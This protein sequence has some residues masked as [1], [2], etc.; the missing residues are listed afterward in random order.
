MTTKSSVFGERNFLFY[1][2]GAGFSLHGTWIQRFAQGWFAWELTS[3]EAWVGVIAFLDFFPVAMLAPAFGVV[4]DRVDRAKMMAWANGLMMLNIAILTIFTLLESVDIIVL[5]I[6]VLIQGILNAMNTPAR[7]SL[8]PNLVSKSKIGSALAS[9]ALLFN[10]SRFIGPAIGGVII[11]VWGVAAAFAINTVTFLIFAI[12]LKQIKL[13]AAHGSGKRHPFRE[14]T[15]G[16]FY[17]LQRPS[18]IWSLIMII[19]VG[20]CVRGAMELMPAFSDVFFGLGSNGQAALT[21]AAGAGAIIG[22]LALASPKSSNTLF[23]WVVGSAG[24]AGISLIVFAI[25]SHFW[26]ALLLMACMGMTVTI[27]GVGVQIIIQSRVNDDYRGRVMS[28]WA[29]LGFGAVALGGLSIGALA[30]PMSLSRATL[31]AGVAC[32]LLMLVVAK[33]FLSRARVID[34]EISPDHPLP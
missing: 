7:L 25:N 19:V 21:S 28:I 22:A 14:L 23:A 18:I 16:F 10:V 27:T 32:T 3:S 24:L 2:V 6:F 4:A 1:F 11:A 31:S 26:L 29:S 17:A 5:L 8:V 33:P 20:F 15:E 9:M 34:Q 13:R 12:A 30:E